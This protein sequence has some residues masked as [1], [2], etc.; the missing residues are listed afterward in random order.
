MGIFVS[1]FICAFTTCPNQTRMV[2]GMAKITAESPEKQAAERMARLGMVGAAAAPASRKV[3][4]P[5]AVAPA[6]TLTAVEEANPATT[7]AKD[8]RLCI[9]VSREQARKIKRYALENDTT[10][11]DLLRGYIDSL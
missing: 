9:I 11:S 3:A 8:Q 5:P 4:I 1:V 7:K 2:E 6:Q 10:V